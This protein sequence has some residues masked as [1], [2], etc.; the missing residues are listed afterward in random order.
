M[1]VE[2]AM[3]QSIIDGLLWDEQNAPCAVMRDLRHLAVNDLWP[4][5][6]FAAIHIKDSLMAQAH[7]EDWDRPCV[8]APTSGRRENL[9][10][11][12]TEL[13]VPASALMSAAETP[14]SRG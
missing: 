13:P 7:S 6:Y 1:E 12:V 4:D 10:T 8:C 2:D 11:C 9:G 3:I 14:A 5:I